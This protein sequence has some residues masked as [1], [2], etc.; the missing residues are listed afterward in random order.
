MSGDDGLLSIEDFALKCGEVIGRSEWLVVDQALVDRFADVSGDH[1]FIHVDPEKARQSA[2]GGTVAHGFLI[3]SLLS[4]FHAEAVPALANVSVAINSGFDRVRFVSPVRTGSRI[5]AVFTLA[6][7][8]EQKPGY[9][10]T[11]LNVEVQIEGSD[12]PAVVADW[13]IIWGITR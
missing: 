10:R 7:C 3:L 2:F 6:E 8:A 11:L 4:A 12:K 1:Q 13:I 5:R 9:W